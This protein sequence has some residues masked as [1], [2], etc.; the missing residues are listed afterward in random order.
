MPKLSWPRMIDKHPAA[1]LVVGR[2]SAREPKG[3]VA[4]RRAAYRTEL[5]GELV[6]RLAKHGDWSITGIKEADG[7]AH[8]HIV[9]ESR[10]DA[11]RVATALHATPMG[12]YP[13]WAS[14]REFLLSA[15]AEEVIAKA[16]VGRPAKRVEA[17]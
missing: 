8:V 3:R 16:L 13:G 7:L 2:L 15:H 10:D 11:L 12:R 1:H 4:N 9:F 5:V 14:Q 6:E 17:R